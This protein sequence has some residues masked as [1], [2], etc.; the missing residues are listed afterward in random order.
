MPSLKIQ[1]FHDDS[2]YKQRN[3]QSYPQ[4]L[5]TT[6]SGYNATISLSQPKLTIK[7]NSFSINF[8]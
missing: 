1:Y 5:W 3:A 4:I 2:N 6:F 8:N 7:N